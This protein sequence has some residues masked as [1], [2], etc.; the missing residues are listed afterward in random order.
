M[1]VVFAILA[2][3]KGHCLP[4]FLECLYNQTYSKKNIHLYIRT[5]DNKDNTVEVIKSFLEK[6]GSEYGSVFYDDT[7][8]SE[9]LKKYAHH[10]WN[11]ERFQI[12]GK[13][14]QDSIEYAKKLGAD[15]FVVDC[16]NFIVPCV[17]EKM[18]LLRNLGV[19]SPMLTTTSAYSNF[20]YDVDKNGYLKASPVYHTIL[21]RD[22]KGIF[23]VKVVHCTYFINNSVLKDVVYDDKS[24]RYEYVIFSDVLRKCGI[25]QYFDN[26]Q[27]YG[28]IV[29]SDNSEKMEND[30]NVTWK[31]T[32][33]E[34][35]KKKQIIV[36][37]NGG[38]GNRIRV[39]NSAIHLAEKLNMDIEHL[40]IGT[41]YKCAFPHVQEIHNKSFE[42]YFEESI[43]KCD[44]KACVVKKAYSE[45][46]PGPGSWHSTQSYGQTLLG[47]KN[48]MN[49]KL[50]DET[51]D[52]SE[53]FLIESSWINH[54]L[55]NEEK[56]AIYSKYFIPR[57]KFINQLEPIE[58]GTIGISIRRG[59]FL[60]YFPEAKLDEQ[61]LIAWLKTFENPVFLCS[62]DKQYVQEMRINLKKPVVFKF[63]ENLEDRGF[64]E[65]L[66]LSKC[67]R[68]YGSI[69]SSFAEEAAFFGGKEY[70]ALSNSFLF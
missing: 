16:D 5:N 42:Y 43:K 18:I 30:L 62:D 53:N 32:I 4:F 38:F 57:G 36:A 70:V 11:C 66:A 58:P 56:H 59:E 44:Y 51:M 50:I 27:F 17:L 3:D 46:S 49:L 8:I 9:S 31:Q 52:T 64:L 60:N 24:Y 68:I 1:S 25:P 22:V 55:T 21:R 45:W 61:Q 23:D 54:N 35:F 10:E 33:T 15:Y 67:S 20:H 69:K 48:L 7:N 29:F 41:E 28:F 6:H 34:H 40:W 19:V 65:F 63:E 14:R 47:I 39:L 13:I 12:L 37:P 26:R 2:K